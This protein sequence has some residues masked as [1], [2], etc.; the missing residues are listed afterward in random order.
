MYPA[1]KAVV[2]LTRRRR[3]TPPEERPKHKTYAVAGSKRS[4]RVKWLL[5]PSPLR[6]RTAQSPDDDDGATG[7]GAASRAPVPQV[8][9]G[10]RAHRQG[11][12]VFTFEPK[13]LLRKL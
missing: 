11:L 12:V 4:E 10:R 2:Q 1:E 13:L 9:G 6:R 8:P 7:A 5:G 3:R